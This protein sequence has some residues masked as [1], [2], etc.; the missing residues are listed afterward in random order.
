MPQAEW[1]LFETVDGTPLLVNTGNGIAITPVPHRTGVCCLTLP[2]NSYR[3]VKA[4]F[5]DLALQ[6][7]A[8]QVPVP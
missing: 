6:L 4:S 8:V 1:L 2:G 7:G 5:D 3:N